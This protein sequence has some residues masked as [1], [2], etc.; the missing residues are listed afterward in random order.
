[1]V[2]EFNCRNGRCAVTLLRVENLSK[3]FGEKVAVDNVSF[4]ISQGTSM[5]LIG[6]SGS[7]KS[8]IAS[9]LLG[10][11]R[12]SDGGIY[13]ANERIEPWRRGQ[14]KRKKLATFVQVVFQDPYLSLDPRIKIGRAVTKVAALHGKNNADSEAVSR[15]VLEAVGL[16]RREQ[17]AYPAELSGGQRQRAAI[18]R[19]LVV[20]PRLLILDEAVASLDVSIQAQILNLLNDLREREGLSYLF[21][22]H[23]LAVVNYVTDYAIVLERGRI[24]EQGKT[25]EL[26]RN[27]REEYTKTLIAAV[28]GSRREH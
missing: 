16:G 23:N 4:S 15:E 28:P 12:P 19:A 3:A 24:V 6:E 27:P 18:A 13:I 7:G 20:K 17:L 22:T 1:M 11:E 5:G 10:L 8:T 2:L 26:L 14:G 9:L 25:H 21:I